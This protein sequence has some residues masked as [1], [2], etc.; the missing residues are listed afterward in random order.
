MLSGT[1]LRVWR[2]S[3]NTKEILDHINGEIARLQQVKSLL[4]GSSNG[5]TRGSAAAANGSS[6][7]KV[8]GKRVLSVEARK[9]IAAAQRKRWAKARKA[10]V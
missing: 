1:L 9:K 2:I 6:S 7:P 5:S 10:Q 4:Q 3:L 8:K